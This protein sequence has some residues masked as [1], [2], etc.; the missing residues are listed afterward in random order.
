MLEIRTVEG[1]PASTLGAGLCL[2]FFSCFLL[3][4]SGIVM[5]KHVGVGDKDSRG[6]TQLPL[7]GRAAV[8]HSFLV[9]SQ[10]IK[11]L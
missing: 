2:P 5:G 3:K 6:S 1:V 7:W 4:Y 10:N 8:Y 11:G 9:Y